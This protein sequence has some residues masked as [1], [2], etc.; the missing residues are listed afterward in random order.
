MSSN[1]SV[2][3]R[4]VDRNVEEHTRIYLG[5]LFGVVLK[6]CDIEGDAK[7]GEPRKAAFFVFFFAYISRTVIRRFKSCMQNIEK[8]QMSFFTRTYLTDFF[9]SVII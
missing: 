9:V 7:R 4:G 3:E 8:H 1:S 2:N 6:S 5:I